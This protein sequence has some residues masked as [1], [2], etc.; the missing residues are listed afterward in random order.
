MKK[1]VMAGKLKRTELTEAHRQHEATI[2]I[3]L[4]PEEKE[5]VEQAAKAEERSVS[6]FVRRTILA[7]IDPQPD[8]SDN[9]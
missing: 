4:T 6:Q 1:L 2:L 3:R 9:D 8:E 5:M 7:V